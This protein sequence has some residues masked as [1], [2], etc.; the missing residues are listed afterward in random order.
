V[1]AIYDGCWS[2]AVGQLGE[3]RAIPR[4]RSCASLQAG[5][6]RQRPVR[7]R[8]RY[9]PVKVTSEEGRAI[10]E[11]DGADLA[12]DAHIEALFG[13]LAVLAT[14]RIPALPQRE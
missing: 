3:V 2:F 13:E 1:H 9:E 7:D 8:H 4:G 12:A 10:D 11:N 6:R 14:L 5:A